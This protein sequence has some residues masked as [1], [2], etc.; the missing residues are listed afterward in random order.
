MPP[1]DLKT[2]LCDGVAARLETES[3]WTALKRL[4][5]ELKVPPGDI[6]TVLCNGVAARI[7]SESFWTALKRLITELKVPPGD[8]KTVLCGGVAARIESESFWVALKRLTTELKVPPA[9]LKSL[10]S[11]SVAARIEDE[12]FLALLKWLINDMHVSIDKLGSFD[13]SLYS[14]DDA[15]IRETIA[16]LTDEYGIHPDDLP[17]RNAFWSH[18]KQDDNLTELRAYLA[19]CRTT[20]AVNARIERLNGRGIGRGATRCKFARPKHV[21]AKVE[22]PKATKQANLLSYFGTK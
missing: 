9:D 8:L 17:A 15:I 11:G 21:P 10:L 6:K 1:A 14:T 19:T 4:I 2:L 13:N 20:G 16:M 3:F 7:E 12:T 5:T 22:P 18:I